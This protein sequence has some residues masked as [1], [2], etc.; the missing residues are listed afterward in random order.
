LNFFSK[1]PDDRFCNPAEVLRAL[2]HDYYRVY[3]NPLLG[4]VVEFVDETGNARHAAVYIADDFVFT[5]NG[6]SSSRP[7]ML[8]RLGELKSYYP[9]RKPLQVLFYRPNNL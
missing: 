4:D 9:T 8:M 1:Q 7:W 2:T 3:S 6:V 5:K